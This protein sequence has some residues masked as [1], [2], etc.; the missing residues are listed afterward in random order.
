MENQ[1]KIGITSSGNSLD[2]ALDPRFGR[3]SG[4]II[5]DTE[6]DEF[7]LIDNKQN[8]NAAQGAGIQ[9]AQN[10]A[11]AGVG[12]VI[13]GK[14]GPKAFQVLKKGGIKVFF[15]NASTVSQALEQFK[16][17]TLIEADSAN[18]NGHWI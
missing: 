9:T 7:E 1:M 17:G 13:T 8:M 15:T 16:A 6:T 2:K 3:A 5:Y 12:C 14:C 10:F 18:V 11:R 4:L